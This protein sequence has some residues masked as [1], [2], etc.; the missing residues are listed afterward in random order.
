VE[1]LAPGTPP[2][3]VARALAAHGTPKALAL[4]GHEPDL[5]QLAARLIGAA[6]PLV[7]R[8]GGVCR[9]ETT[10]WPPG[11]DSRLIWFATPKILRRLRA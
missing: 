3:R 1:A 8:K 10:D 5:G 2:A 4:V 9:I 11:R 6:T 7:F